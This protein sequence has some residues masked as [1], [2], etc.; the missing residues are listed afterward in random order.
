MAAGEPTQ[1]RESPAVRHTAL[2]G[3]YVPREC[4]IATFTKDLRD[5]IAGT[6]ADTQTL[7]VA[8][9]DV[10]EGY[11][12]P[13]EVQFQLQAFQNRDYLTAADLLNINQVDVALIQHEY[14]IYGGPDGSHVLT[15]MANLRMPIVVTLHTV[16][17]EPSPGQAEVMTELAKRSDRLVVMSHLAARMLQDVYEIPKEKVL[18]IPHGIPDVPFVDPAYYKDQFALEGRR[19]L[20]T[21]GL[22]SPGKG[23]QVAIEAL[24]GIVEK[25]PDLVYVVLGATH[26][27]IFKQ[28]GNAYR[29]SLERLAEKLGVKEHVVFHNR[30]V[31]LE[32]LC[33]YIGAA[34][35]YLTPYL[36]KAQIVSGTLAYA[37]GSGKAIVSTPIW[38]AEELLAEGRGRLVPFQDPQ[39]IAS[40]VNE[41]LD[42][43]SARNTMRKRAYALGRTMIW[44][45]VGSSYVRLAEDVIGQRLRKPRRA[46]YLREKV[47]KKASMPDVDLS[48]LR[49]LTDD[50]GVLQHA[51]FG[52]PDRSQG[53]TTD[54]NA[55]ALIATLMYYDGYRDESALPLANTYLAFLYH[56]FDPERHRFRNVMGFDRRWRDERVSEDAHGRALWALGVA[57][58][59]AP[60]D[61]ILSCATRL[62]CQAL[63]MAECFT[64]PRAWA[65]ALIGIHAY[66]RR[67]D[68]DTHARRVRSVLAKRLYGQFKD[69]SSP[70]WPWC[71]DILCYSNAKLVHALILSGQWIPSPRMVAQG[72]KS[73]QWLL[74]LQLR[75]DGTVSLIGNQGWMKR[76]GERARFG[77]QPVD[78]MALVEACAEAHRCTQEA[79]WRER[80][81]QCLGW[82]LGNN[83]IQS[84]IYD[85]QTGGCRDGLH[86]DGANVNQGAESS[87]AWL[88]ALVT[89]HDL[90]RAALLKET[91]KKAGSREVRKKGIGKSG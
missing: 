24:P 79:V 75:K 10:P 35:I 33:G 51:V 66:L 15:L 85:Y 63:E 71:E 78:A 89:M 12:Y 50:T 65:F 38:Y 46:F 11:A 88:I 14:G 26:P 57:A 82:F 17:A 76:G 20:L 61:T 91:S 70:D 55:R 64:A 2:V 28:E 83:D 40:A 36:N 32:E 77:Q 37:L 53:Y 54:D 31:S 68:G 7:V 30:F 19:V 39:A 44:P 3:S 25:H 45:E 42:D 90:D 23:I 74:K 84:V 1:R 59:L 87:L 47:S 69:N 81:H 43:E 73:L 34:D 16:L 21:F 18:F 52:V 27:H 22:L 72:L 6:G 8:M 49:T 48:H 67:F 41:L 13:E 56:A 29:D 9:D 5:A 86:P 4:G 60:N 58:A 80:A 62:F